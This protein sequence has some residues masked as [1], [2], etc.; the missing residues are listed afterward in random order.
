MYHLDN[1]SGVPE[2]PEPKEQQS[3]TPR[4]FG[5]SQEQGGISWPGADWFNV[6]QAELL[7][8]LAAAGIE[9]EK[10]AYDQLSKAIPVLGDAG[11]R[12]DLESEGDSLGGNMIA[13]PWGGTVRHA[14]DKVITLQAMGFL[15]DGS[16]ETERLLSAI[17]ALEA[18]ND[19]WV[20]EGKG[21]TVT[22]S[23]IIYIDL[24]K[25]GLRN[26]IFD[27]PNPALTSDEPFF[28]L[29]PYGSSVEPALTESKNSRVVFDGITIVGPSVRCQDKVYGLLH[30]PQ[31][32]YDLSNVDFRNL[33][34]RKCRAGIVFG[35]N[36]YLHTY[37][38]L[39][40]YNCHA[41]VVDTVWVGY[42][43]TITN[44][45]ENIRFVDSTLANNN[46]VL[47]M[48]GM[49]CYL[50][51]V[52]TSFDYNGGSP[53]V[54]LNQWILRK[55]GITLNLYNCHFESG[56]QYDGVTA[57]YFYADKSVRV[58]IKGGV[59]QFGNTVYN[60]MPYLFYDGSG[61]A[62]FSLKD[63][64]IYGRGIKEFANSSMRECLPEVN[65]GTSGVTPLIQKKGLF[66]L[67]PD[68]EMS[69]V[70]DNWHVSGTQTSR[71]ESEQL[72]IER[73]FTTDGNGNTIPA[74]K[75]TRKPGSVSCLAYLYVKKPRNKF[76]G[77]SVVTLKAD[78]TLTLS[79]PVAI[80]VGMIKS[81]S[82]EGSFGRPSQDV[83]LNT[84][85]VSADSLTTTPTEFAVG[86]TIDFD[87]SY[88][89]YDLLRVAINITGLSTTDAVYITSIR[90]DCP[91]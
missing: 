8:L 34:I 41:C 84:H 56:N 17:A 46:M 47:A 66:L 25:V 15:L 33:T 24:V 83:I 81:N 14:L 26:I 3:M 77:Y 55:Q 78:T 11:L 79:N 20:I 13:L 2:M 35:S 28:I 53:D 45:G 16:D 74:L 18:K 5:E 75:L 90:L 10:H 86:G 88:M 29:A 21:A 12:D 48:G 32:T 64:Y 65:H 38:N 63:T 27:C 91:F 69:G 23:Q 49:E 87:P 30:N 67:D 62:D 73:T 50:T 59:M 68:F 72:K 4:W 6:V 57:S 61:L 36:T 19:K 76:R 43:T 37:R 82:V 54:S 44:A 85:T 31:K 52:N 9:P 70:A 39:N 80:Q 89:A 71:L 7:N 58:N 22:V 42:E 51:F 60:N 1:T 40:I